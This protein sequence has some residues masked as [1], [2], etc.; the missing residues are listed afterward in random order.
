MKGASLAFL[1][2][3]GQGWKGPPG[4][5]TLAVLQTFVN[6]GG[7]KFYNIEPW[8]DK[9]MKAVTALGTVM[10]PSITLRSPMQC[11]ALH[12]IKSKSTL[13]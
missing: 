8:L 7:K 9:K 11:S 6:Y 10:K 1:A 4:S 2:N 12:W 5:D 13:L 3:F